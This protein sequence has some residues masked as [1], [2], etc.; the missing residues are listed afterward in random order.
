M[1][2]SFLRWFEPLVMKGAPGVIVPNEFMRDEANRRFGVD[3]FIVR[4]ACD[5]TAYDTL[6][7]G[8]SRI[9]ARPIGDAGVRIVYTGGVGHLSFSDD[10]EFRG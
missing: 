3:P 1:G 4:N 2:N 9:E 8:A 10:Y 5:L 6:S 7:L